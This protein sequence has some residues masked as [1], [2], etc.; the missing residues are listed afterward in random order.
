MNHRWRHHSY[1]LAPS[2]FFRSFTYPFVIYS[3]TAFF[4]PC[5]PTIDVLYPPRPLR[6]RLTPHASRVSLD[7][8]PHRDPESGT[9]EQRRFRDATPDARRP[10]RQQAFRS[11]D[12][13]RTIW[14]QVVFKRTSGTL[15]QVPGIPTTTTTVDQ[16]RCACSG[17]QQQRDKGESRQ[18]QATSPHLT[19]LAAPAPIPVLIGTYQ[20]GCFFL[21]RLAT[22]VSNNRNRSRR[23]AQI[24][25]APPTSQ[26][27]PA[28]TNRTTIRLAHTYT[29]APR[30]SFPPS[31]SSITPP[32]VFRHDPPLPIS[33]AY[34]TPRLL[35][36]N[37]NDRQSSSVICQRYHYYHHHPASSS[38]SLS[39]GYH[40]AIDTDQ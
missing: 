9:N 6:S 28:P 11:T 8:H 38:V 26:K 12:F 25:D 21:C 7:E 29:L 33:L 30:R 16:R 10:P 2:C 4:L 32:F 24:D 34:T 3:A 36:Y 35:S 19:L 22:R 14:P 13:E 20:G 39:L 40:A 37:T 18:V 15:G 27:T 5:S 31:S 17:H 1:P 23:K